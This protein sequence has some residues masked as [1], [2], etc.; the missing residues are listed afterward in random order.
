MIAVENNLS[1]QQVNFLIQTGE[2]R[3]LWLQTDFVFRVLFFVK[4]SITALVS[5]NA[6]PFNENQT[7]KTRRLN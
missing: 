2:D 7:T 4:I 1:E 3:E 6:V 5:M